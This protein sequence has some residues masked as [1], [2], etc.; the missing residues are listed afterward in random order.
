LIYSA[1]GELTQYNP[2]ARRL[3][4]L[5]VDRVKLSLQQRINLLNAV[6]TDGQPMKSE[7][8]PAYQAMHGNTVRNF[9]SRLILPD[10][11]KP[12]WLSVSASPIRGIE[13]IG[14][15][16]SLTDITEHIELEEKLRH[17]QSDLENRVMQRTADLQTSIQALANAN[18]IMQENEE[19][20]R[21]L[22]ENIH[23]VFL[24]ESIDQEKILYVSPA[25]EDLWGKTRQSLYDHPTSFLDSIHPEDLPRVIQVLKQI[26]KV[27]Y[28]EQYRIIR[29]D[30]SQRWVRARTFPILNEAGKPYRLAGIIEDITERMQSIQLLEKRVD[31]RTREL[32]TLLAVSNSLKSTLEFNQL[33][34]RVLDQLT[35][36]VTFTS[37]IVLLVEKEEI[38]VVAIRGFFHQP[39]PLHSR[40]PVATSKTLAHLVSTHQAILINDIHDQ[41]SDLKLI[42]PD[43]P[44][45]DTNDINAI[46]SWLGVPMIVKD[47]VVGIVRM[48]HTQPEAFTQ[49][50]VQLVQAI[51]N[52]AAVA[53]ENARLYGQAK[54]LAALNER[55]RL[56][57]ELHDSVSQALYSISLVS[58]FALASLDR[59]P[60]KLKEALEYILS[61]A[62]A[63][64]TE[65]RALI[66]ELRPES[67]ATEGLVAAIK[68][69]TLAL[70][71]R[72]GIHVSTWLDEEPQAPLEVK[73]ALFRIVQEALSNASRHANPTEIT[74]TVKDN[75]DKIEMTITDDGKG[76]D[77]AQFFAG[78]LGLQSMRERAEQA[79][80]LLSKFQKGNCSAA[81]RKMPNLRCLCV[82]RTRKHLKFGSFSH[83]PEET[84]KVLIQNKNL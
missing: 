11:D 32:T 77:P 80:G 70:E 40:F 62:D 53:I 69:Q 24:I 19:R 6:Q 10:T 46:G 30:G 60:A 58:H 57:R 12:I 42:F 13:G 35:N 76:F 63:G 34:E 81:R 64:L 59:D 49:A 33:I 39:I 55:Q 15:V 56:A 84:Q 78:H 65:M 48:A 54:E 18:A 9:V 71:V 22:A 79:H 27:P 66:F 74:L 41:N 26:P 7:D 82:L 68:R 28:D 23:E 83:G 4:G 52:Q 8:A 25:Y 73:E 51:A 47:V 31:E 20:F 37:A 3:I 17:V 36:I 72:R 14:A 21:Q 45:I 50:H 75:P 2:A 16:V 67:L 38:E 61:L 1:G 44:L 43:R 29:S 5:N